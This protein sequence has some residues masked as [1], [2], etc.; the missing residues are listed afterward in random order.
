M[1]FV[2]RRRRRRS[3]TNRDDSRVWDSIAMLT[4]RVVVQE[5]SQLDTYQ[6]LERLSL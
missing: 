1:P 6:G 3:S 4:V 2:K 5:F